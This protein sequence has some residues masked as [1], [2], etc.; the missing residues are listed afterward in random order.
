MFTRMLNT[1]SFVETILSNMRDFAEVRKVAL[2]PE[3][4]NPDPV[5]PMGPSWNDLS[6][7]NGYPSLLIL[8]ST[9]EKLGLVASSDNIAHSY[10]VK[11]KEAVEAEGLFNLSL[12]G[13]VSGLCF[14]L[15]E[16]SFEGTRYQRMLGALN[17][18][19]LGRI[20]REYLEPLK[21]N[22]RNQLPSSPRLYD[23]IQGI[24][25]IG[26]YAL[27]NLTLPSFK[28]LAENIAKASVALSL[29]LVYKG[30]ATAGWFLSPNDPL[31]AR[32]RAANPKGN[33]NLGLA[34]GVTGILA[35]LAIAWLRGVQVE[36]QKEAMLAI[37]NWIRSKSYLHE[38]VIGWPYTVSWEEEIEGAPVSVKGSKEAWCYGVPGIARTLFLTGKALGDEEMKEFAMKAFRGVFS[39]RGE[40]WGLPGPT[41]CHGISG[42]L[43]IT[44]MMSKE[45]G[46]EDLAVRVEELKEILLSYYNPEAPWGFKDVEFTRKGKRCEVNKPGF[47]E[48][49]AGIV[50]TLLT[51]SQEMPKW[52]LPLLIHE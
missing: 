27:E 44:H 38:G 19:L 32:N 47:L 43:L 3:N 24:S 48:G 11:I 51:L 16:A 4:M 8:F 35:F 15:Q 29:P 1:L 2:D 50:L 36:G 42:L 26:R 30:Q 9:L 12:Y 25:G 34:H 31:N 17:E 40:E 33:F 28:E 7:S 46:G 20:D 22:L 18:V 14:A 21:Y 5:I 49:S 37:A 45:A 39:R 23:P 13:G 10:V 6:L 41:L 52:H